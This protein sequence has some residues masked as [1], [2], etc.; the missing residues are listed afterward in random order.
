[1]TTLLITIA[2]FA[3][4]MLAFSL[5]ILAGRARY[6]CSCK[7]A[8]RVMKEYESA[9]CKGCGESEDKE[10]VTLEKKSPKGRP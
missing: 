4:V 6:Q 3:L 5:S 1:M 7:N 2:V 9:A 10:L 8:A